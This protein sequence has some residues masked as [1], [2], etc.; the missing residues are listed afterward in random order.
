ME[1]AQ[2]VHVLGLIHPVRGFPR[3]AKKTLCS[4]D[5]KGLRGSGLRA[6][7]IRL[8]LLQGPLNAPEVNAPEGSSLEERLRQRVALVLFHVGAVGLEQNGERRRGDVLLLQTRRQTVAVVP[9]R[10]HLS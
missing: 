8:S 10:L 6:P 5:Q 1:L 2:G 4:V 3:P 9:R 7:Q